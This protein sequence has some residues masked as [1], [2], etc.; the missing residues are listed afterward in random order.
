[1]EQALSSSDYAQAQMNLSQEAR[2]ANNALSGSIFAPEENRYT[3]CYTSDLDEALTLRTA[4]QVRFC[5][6][7]SVAVLFLRSVY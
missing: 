7:T 2:T 6:V 5:R 1:M 3:L 4:P